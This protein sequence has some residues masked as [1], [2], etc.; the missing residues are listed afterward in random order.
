MGIQTTLPGLA[1]I[2]NKWESRLI[3]AEVIA[4][5]RSNS[6][7]AMTLGSG[8]TRSGGIQWQESQ[9]HALRSFAPVSGIAAQ[10]LSTVVRLAP[11]VFRGGLNLS[12]AQL[13]KSLAR[14]GVGA[15]V[16]ALSPVPVVGQIAQAIGGVVNLVMQLAT[17]N[18]YK[19]KELLPPAQD[20]A[21]EID[22]YLVNTEILP[23]LETLNWTSVF[24][25]RWK[26][27]W[28]LRKRQGQAFAAYA[29]TATGNTGMIPHTQQI[30]SKIQLRKTDPRSRYNEY[31]AQDTGSF[32]PGASQMLTQV[33]Q[34]CNAA[35]TQ[36][37]N[38]DTRAIKSAWD[39]YC[40]GAY[41]LAL[42]IFNGHAPTLKDAGISGWSAYDRKLLA[43]QFI[44]RVSVGANNIIGNPGSGFE[45]EKAKKPN[46][47]STAIVA[48]W[49]DRQRQR[50]AHYLGTIVGAAYTDPKQAAFLDPAL[51][52]RLDLMRATLLTHPAK[53]RVNISSMID[54]LFRTLIFQGTVGDTITAFPPSAKVAETPFESDPVPNA[55][56]E[57]LEGGFPFAPSSNGTS[58]LLLAALGLGAY[59]MLKK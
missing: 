52:S 7:V 6:D 50:Q 21:E 33:L 32:Y 55:P 10:H 1:G 18:P 25:P 41:A 53:R 29:E 38:V 31:H 19:R 23:A 40:E 59:A 34:F 39:E 51:R 47:V 37:Y 24:M 58:A 20:Y 36:M 56:V 17:A 22:E 54:P 57:P 3:T 43:S 46:L 11:E 13:G 16:T 49:C 42:R 15:A 27:D 48:P 8:L 35:Q 28:V 12:V 2:G 44:S 5:A 30:T 9:Q 4:H 14:I 26:G 45:L